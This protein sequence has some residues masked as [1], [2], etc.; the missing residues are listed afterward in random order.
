MG[1]RKRNYSGTTDSAMSDREIRNRKLSEMAGCE[2]AVLLKNNGLLPIKKGS[3]IFLAGQGAIH[4]IKGGTGSGDVNERQ[5]VDFLAGLEN[6]NYVV[7]NASLVK[8]AIRDYEDARADYR[9]RVL[10]HVDDSMGSIDVD[11]F[12]LLEKT[13]LRPYKSIPIDE[14]LVK[15]AD[16]CVYVISRKAGE[17]NDRYANPG[18][19]YLSQE[20]K[21]DLETLSKLTDRILVVLNVGGQIDMSWILSIESV[22]AI[23]NISQ[24]G[25]EIG[26]VL[27][28]LISGQVTPS[29]KL[30]GTWAKSY[31][32]YPSSEHFSHNDGNLDNDT[33]T[34]GIYV[35]YRY[36]DSF[37]VKPEFC[38]GY[39]LS[40]TEFEFN[41]MDASAIDGRIN[42]KTEIKNV[43]KKFSGKEVMQVYLAC[44]RK[45][46][47]KE[48]K[49]LVAFKKT[50]LLSPGQSQELEAS[51]GSKDMASFDEEKSQWI[52]EKGKYALLVGN[53]SENVKL[54]KVIS[55]DRDYVIE[56]VGHV[57]AAQSFEEICPE[58]SYLKSFENKWAKE[59]I[60]NNIATINFI[61]QKENKASEGRHDLDEKARTI[62]DKLTDREIAYV[63]MGEI[64]KGQDNLKN[65]QLVETGIFVP[66]AAGETT[67]MLEE[68]YDIPAISMADGPAGLRL[69]RTYDVD[70]ET[71]LIYSKDIL[72]SIENG[73]FAR[74][75]DNPNSRKYYMYAT[76]IPIGTCLAQSF[77]LDLVTELGKMVGAEMEEFKVSWWLAPGMNIQRNPLCGRNFEYYSED[78]L[79]SGMMA[80]AITRG[81]QSLPGIGTTIKHFA[82]N[83]Q[84]DNRMFVDVNVSERA[85]RE[86]YLRGFEIAVKESQPMCIMTSYNKINGVSSA[87][88]RDLCTVLAR[89]EWGFEGIIMSDWITTV[90]GAAQSH[91]CALAGNDLIMPGNQKD[92]KDI[93]EALES[94]KLPREIARQSA[95]RIIKVVLQTLGMEECKPY[96]EQFSFK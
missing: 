75:Y 71:G 51:F 64:T 24:P 83:N 7:V 62:A 95:A 47:N 65:N 58:E 85:L 76:A 74:D 28:D 33:Y 55:V 46:I 67:C 18:D 66:G 57:M 54:A 44:P 20:E 42:V 88:N 32:D 17:G 70:N 80:A 56:E 16:S 30:T 4:P 25:M 81:V 2:G 87:N 92:V 21:S 91:Q 53:S 49:R 27:S 77:N 78:P 90:A 9:Q 34:D 68:K 84:E 61:P 19:Y 23:L 59:E 14:S 89:D 11:L 94:G 93:M 73:F 6:K 8:E 26:N 41:H 40:Y 82:C 50:G 36:F 38:F 15:N 10:S 5:I 48:L 63:L 45:G 37:N 69:L 86:I 22:G 52:V 96:M 3:K 60:E 31:K 43:G 1:R 29:G 35:G 72:S 12:E 13:K 79:L 39:G